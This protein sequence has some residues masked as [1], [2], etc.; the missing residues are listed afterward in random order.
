MNNI[1]DQCVLNVIKDTQLSDREKKAQHPAG[2][3]PTTSSCAT[4][5]ALLKNLFE[6]D[7]HILSTG[8]TLRFLIGNYL[9]DLNSS[10]S[11]VKSNQY[12]ANRAAL[13]EK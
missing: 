6:K 5:A 2:F 10:P 3:K 12:S 4:T 9:S 1:F 7:P 13:T 8:F 11:N